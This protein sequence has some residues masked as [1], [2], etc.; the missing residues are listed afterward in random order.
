MLSRR[1]ELCELSASFTGNSQHL[2][3]CWQFT[4]APH[5]WKSCSILSCCVCC[6][7]PRRVGAVLHRAHKQ[8]TGQPCR[9]GYPNACSKT[10]SCASHGSSEGCC[11]QGPHV[12]IC[13]AACRSP[14]A[15]GCSRWLRWALF[16]LQQRG[17]NANRAG[18]K[19]WPTGCS[20]PA[21]THMYL[22]QVG[23]VVS[24]CLLCS[25]RRAKQVPAQHDVKP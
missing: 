15:P 22:P 21:W 20:L 16:A 24:H 25:R 23:T 4:A 12:M 8:R 10:I 11:H 9:N 13:H 7:H 3:Y 19:A 14:R 5:V 17:C 18:S 2:H 6:R 1:S